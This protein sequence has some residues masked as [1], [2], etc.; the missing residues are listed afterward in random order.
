MELKAHM[1]PILWQGG[2]S[3]P[4]S[5]MSS[6]RLATRGMLFLDRT[7]LFNKKNIQINWE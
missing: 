3:P 6:P 2:N 4:T 1:T 5:D 7:T